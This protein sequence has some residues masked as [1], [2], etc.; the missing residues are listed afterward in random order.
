MDRVRV[1]HR[2][3]RF[4]IHRDVRHTTYSVLRL[5][6]FLRPSGGATGDNLR[7]QVSLCAHRNDG[8]HDVWY[9]LNGPG[10]YHNY[11]RMGDTV[12]EPQR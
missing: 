11:N 1:G 10:D 2:I 9:D 12:Q 5:G 4:V 7:V 6:I 3:F 8:Y